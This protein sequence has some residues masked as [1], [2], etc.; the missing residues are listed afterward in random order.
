V[1]GAGKE[2]REFPVEFWEPVWAEEVERLQPRSV[3]RVQAEKARRQI[4][5]GRRLAWLR[6]DPFGPL[7]LPLCRKLYVPLGRAGASAA[8]FGFFFRLTE[9]HGGL[10]WRLIAFGQRH[11][12][13]PRTASVYRRAFKRLHS[14]R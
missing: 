4:E 1:S 2:G 14:G 12:A 9:T 6:Y 3:A 13:N 7:G 8:P 11:P 5:T 10:A